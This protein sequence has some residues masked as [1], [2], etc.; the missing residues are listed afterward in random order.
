MPLWINSENRSV[1]SPHKYKYC[2]IFQGP[3]ICIHKFP[4]VFG[5]H[6]YFLNFTAVCKFSTRKWQWQLTTM[7]I[8]PLAFSS[9]HFKSEYRY[10]FVFKFYKFSFIPLF[11]CTKIICFTKEE[12]QNLWIEILKLPCHISSILQKE[13]FLNEFQHHFS[14]W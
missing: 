1:K 2:W 6:I 12:K 7:T 10:I 3:S 13:L 11:N 4:Y 8:F 9:F 5:S 14:I